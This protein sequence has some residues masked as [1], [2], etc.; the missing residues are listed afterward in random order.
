MDQFLSLVLGLFAFAFL[1]FM[2]QRAVKGIILIGCAIIAFLV[3][4]SL[5]VIG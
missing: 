5:G 1:I 3:L 2:I 4:T